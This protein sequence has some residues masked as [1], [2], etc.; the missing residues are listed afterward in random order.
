LTNPLLILYR[1][2]RDRR[3][4]RAASALEI[5]RVRYNTFRFL[6]TNNEYSLELLRSVDRTLLSRNASWH[7]L[8]EEIDELLH[9]TYEMIDGLDRLSEG[10]YKSLFARHDI[11]ERAI[12]EEVDGLIEDS[13]FRPS[14]ISFEDL[15]RKEHGAAVGGKAVTLA[16]LRRSGIPVPDGFAVTAKACE[17]IISAAGLDDFIH[18]RM[19][20][21]ESGRLSLA[22]FEEIEAEI[23]AR[24]SAPTI[25]GILMEELLAFYS[26]LSGNGSR[27]ISVRSSALLEDRV[28]HSFA[29]QFKSVLNVTSFE[30]FIDA[31]KEVI[32][33]A[34]G[35]RALTY[36]L[37]AGLP[38]TGRDIALFCQEMVPARTAGVLFTI[39]P[40]NPESGRMLISA[41]PGLGIIAVN[42]SAP[43]DL[44]RPL[45]TRNRSEPLDAM[46]QIVRKTIRAAC[47]DS[48]GIVELPVPE[49]EQPDPTLTGE[50]LS[51]LVHLGRMIEDLL[52][53]PQDIE[54][55]ISDDG[56]PRI[57]QSREMRFSSKGRRAPRVSGEVI[58]RGGVCASPGRGIGRVRL[59]HSNHNPERADAESSGPEVMVLRQSF[60][61]AAALLPFFEGAVVELGNPADHLSCIAREYSIP[62]ITGAGK[63]SRCLKE[64]EWV[65]IDAE[66]TEILRAPEEVWSRAIS[67]RERKSV[68]RK[69]GDGNAP[70]ERL[71]APP[72]SSRLREL[73][74]PLNLTD[75]Y[76]PTFS[77]VECRSLHDL[78]RFTHEMAVLSMF[79]LGDK[80]IEDAEALVHVLS[81][82][83]PFCFLIIDLGGGLTPKTHGMKISPADLVSAPMLAM[84]RGMKTRGL[85]WN[86]PPPATN[87]TGLL[88][89]SLLDG[90]CA[91]PVGQQ[92][93]ALISRDY[94]NLNARVDYHF[95]MV[96]SICGMSARDN[97]IRFRFKG[98][99]TTQVQ[100]ERRARFIAEVLEK[101][102]FF[103]DQ[104]GDLVTGTIL[105][106]EKEDIEERLMMLGRLM[107]FSRL[108]DASMVDDSMPGK[109][110]RAFR[111]GDFGLND[112]RE[113]PAGTG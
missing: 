109:M 65:V 110:A 67:G 36:R 98:G 41:V 1:K 94:L 112:F 96:D 58:L 43:A 47:S 101:N 92:N 29:G 55:A 81:G 40:A 6:L 69:S 12:R 93:Y 90:A 15:T 62:M 11:I 60:V 19:R 14:C 76:G 89:R 35:R 54:W 30:A 78:I 84:L 45:R 3:Q 34:Y 23:N 70:E 27:A 99:G 21:A 107:G 68:F 77:A 49:H 39:D 87:I 59:I 18:G 80:V 53:K 51:S 113:E 37:H 86:K 50:E 2:W 24:L 74:E 8:S 102:N 66:K 95:T 48:G 79:R 103:T 111:D 63:A 26:R 73:I 52:G 7:D 4:F 32:A 17:E 100:R 105:E 33:S 91:R 64:G 44:Y 108:L 10:S 5:L 72:R 82:G 71:K 61:D 75:S 104:R 106:M 25:P 28:E 20:Q 57:L 97:Y 9:V 85:R 56:T 42:G 46:S 31:V 22:G 83:T 13:G 16:F 38:L 88:S